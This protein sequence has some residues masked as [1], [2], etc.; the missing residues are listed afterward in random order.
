MMALDRESL[1]AAHWSENQ[2]R[3]LFASNRVVLSASSI[4]DPSR[5]LS[6]SESRPETMLGFIVASPIPPEWELENI[7]VAPSARRAGVA[8]ALL[9]ALLEI[10]RKTKSEAV[11]LEVRESNDGA[12][13]FYE[14][15]GFQRTGRRK[16][17]YNGPLEDAILYRIDL[18]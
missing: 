11:F 13:A 14:A 18:R 6:P 12:R 2:Y 5:R 17:Y 4:P 16:S 7:V 8:I 15:A 1:T 10:V 9:K 3:D